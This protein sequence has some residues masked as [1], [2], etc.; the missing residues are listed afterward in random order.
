MPEL[1]VSAMKPIAILQHERN[2]GPGYLLEYLQCNG[3][4]VRLLHP[5]QG[6]ALPED[7]RHFS[8]LVVLGSNH[9]VNDA[10]AWIAHERRL[11]ADAVAREV[12]VLGHCFGA[13]QLARS[14]GARVTKAMCPHIGWERV[15]T[16]PA[17]RRC[18]PGQREAL[19]F[20]WHYE[21][22]EIPRGASRMLFGAHCLNKGF[23]MGPHMAFQGHL[24]VTEGSVRDWCDEGR[25]E[26]LAAWGPAAQPL[27]AILDHLPERTARLHCVA[28]GFYGRWV[29]GLRRARIHLAWA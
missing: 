8:G 29:A 24:E 11:V 17:S 25:R 23:V 15:W 7:A 9:S 1:H 5:A 10:C 13:Q 14:Q 2:Q 6:D 26:L 22:F 28:E 18:L 4:P 19:F 27:P 21:T 20:N 16:T 12:P 3:L